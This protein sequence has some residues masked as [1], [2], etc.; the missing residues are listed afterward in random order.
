MLVAAEPQ[1]HAAMSA[2]LVDQA[3]APL[4]VAERD[5]AF[6]QQLDPHR[7]TIVLRQFFGQQGRDPVAPEEIA[8][9]GAGAGL[10]QEVVL[11]LAKHGAILPGELVR[12]SATPAPPAAPLIRDGCETKSAWPAGLTSRSNRLF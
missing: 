7:R 6:A 1:R 12:F 11:F 2:E 8:H 3:V 9:R 4:A 5:H 10:G